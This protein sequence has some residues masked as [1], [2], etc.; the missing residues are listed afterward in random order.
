MEHSP[1]PDDL[2]KGALLKIAQSDNRSPFRR[3]WEAWRGFGKFLGDW[4]ARILL[5]IFYFTL[6]APFGIG[7][8]MASD[9]LAT[10]GRSRPRWRQRTTYERQLG[11]AKRMG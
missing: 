5:T 4:L 9:P 10:T 2:R 8:R 11:E 7:V 3:A 1:I 6:L